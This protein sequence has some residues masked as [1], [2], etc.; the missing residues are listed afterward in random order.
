[1][2]SI[3]ISVSRIGHNNR[4]SSSTFKMKSV[5]SIFSLATAEQLIFCKSGQKDACQFAF[6]K[7]DGYPNDSCNVID[8]DAQIT[9][10]GES[11]FKTLESYVAENCG[12]RG[13][14]NDPSVTTDLLGYGCWC[15]FGQ[16]L[17]FG[18]GQPVDLQ[19]KICRQLNHNYRCIEIDAAAEGKTCPFDFKDYMFLMSNIPKN[20]FSV[21]CQSL[22]DMLTSMIPNLYKP[23]DSNCAVRRCVS[24]SEFL[25]K[26]MDLYVEMSHPF[27]EDLEW[28]EYGGSFDKDTCGTRLGGEKVEP[29]CCAEYPDRFPIQDSETG[30]CINKRY[31]MLIEDCCMDGVFPIGFC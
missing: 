19:D 25:R 27:N 15:S 30:C 3:Q 12:M 28:I 7:L 9:V 2:G 5:L 21:E 6:D 31:N 11:S 8:T 4:K 20:R 24:D 1:M 10:N 22:H 26:S 14:G 23:E 16:K 13:V 29:I 18:V 17:K